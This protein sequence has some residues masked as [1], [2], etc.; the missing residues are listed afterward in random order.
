MP[1]VASPVGLSDTEK[2]MASVVCDNRRVVGRASVTGGGALAADIYLQLKNDET[3]PGS[4]YY[5]GTD[6]NGNKGWHKLPDDIIDL[7]ALV[8]QVANHEVRITALEAWIGTDGV[9]WAITA[10]DYSVATGINHVKC[11]AAGITITLPAADSVRAITVKNQ[12]DGVVA[13][14][15]A[16]LIDTLNTVYLAGREGGQFV[17]DGTLWNIV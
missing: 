10:V 9:V 17:A 15:S 14:T 3:T 8:A 5:Y 13:V 2:D 4:L 11:T 16:S 6:I 7:A 12:T 1:G